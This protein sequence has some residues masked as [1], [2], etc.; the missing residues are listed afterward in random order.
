MEVKDSFRSEVTRIW[1][2]CPLELEKFGERRLLDFE[3]RHEY[4]VV[5]WVLL[6]FWQAFG[7]QSNKKS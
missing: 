7:Y 6:S 4:S 1:D 3:Y 5:A 2:D